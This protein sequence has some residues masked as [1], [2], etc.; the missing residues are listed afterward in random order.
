MLKKP[1]KEVRSRFINSES[2]SKLWKVDN[3]QY[4][5]A[6]YEM[7]VADSELWTVDRQNS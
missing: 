7:L 1:G 4:Q 3:F 6:L 5:E 2:Y